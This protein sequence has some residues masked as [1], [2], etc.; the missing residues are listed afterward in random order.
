MGGW[1]WDKGKG[2][3]RLKINCIKSQR[4]N[5]NSLKNEVK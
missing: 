5:K 2:V 1:R 4:I 3:D